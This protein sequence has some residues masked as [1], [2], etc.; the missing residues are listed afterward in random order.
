VHK[1][2]GGAPVYHRLRRKPRPENIMTIERFAHFQFDMSAA[3]LPDRA[4]WVPY[5]EIRICNNH[6]AAGDVIF[7]KQRISAE[8]VYESEQAA[9]EEARRFAI[10]H[11]SSGEY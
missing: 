4:G 2:G 5:L 1:T 7:P 9:I 10:S 8:D 3:Q 6:E 11:V